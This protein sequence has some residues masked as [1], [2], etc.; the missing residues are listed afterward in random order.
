MEKAHMIHGSFRGLAVIAPL[1]LFSV[2][3]RAERVTCTTITALPA[4]ISAP[5]NYCL[6]GNLAT[7]EPELPAI[8]IQSSNVRLNCNGNRIANTADNKAAGIVIGQYYGAHPDDVVIENCRVRGFLYGITSADF[9]DNLQIRDNT[10]ELAS[11]IGMLIKTRR[12]EIT[13]NT[14]VDMRTWRSTLLGCQSVV[15]GMAIRPQDELN[16]VEGRDVLVAGNHI[17]D[18]GGGCPEQ[19]TQALSIGGSSRAIVRDNH[20][21]GLPKGG[22]LFLGNDSLV[23]DNVFINS[24]SYPAYVWNPGPVCRGNVIVGADQETLN[25]DSTSNAIK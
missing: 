13:G 5:G 7:M 24:S 15:I 19:Q 23:T 21:S 10:I 3:A 17:L 2:S 14:I 4:T 8:S 9:S 20:V 16:N 18:I 12:G 25:C 11:Y 22:W 1:L 6:A